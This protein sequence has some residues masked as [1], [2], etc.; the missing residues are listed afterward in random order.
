MQYEELFTDR[1]RIGT[2]IEA[3]MKD[4][5]CTKVRLSKELNVSRP[6]LD[7]ILRGDIHNAG[8]YD[9][10]IKRLLAY[11]QISDTVLNNYK[12][13]PAVE[14]M[15]CTSVDKE[16]VGNKLRGQEIPVVKGNLDKIK[17]RAFRL[18][19]NDTNI[20]A[21]SY[22]EGVQSVL[23]ALYEEYPDAV[24][25]VANVLDKQAAS[26]MVDCGAKFIIAPCQ[27]DEIGTFC[28]ARDVFCMMGATTLSEVINVMDKGGDVVCLYPYEAVAKETVA[29]LD[30]LAKSV[31]VATF[32]I[33]KGESL[34]DE[35][36]TLYYV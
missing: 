26:I 34:V 17:A 35:F 2:N 3:I 16:A 1:K 32:S 5:K 6:T 30:V 21:L 7:A 29:A 15:R 36:A 13:L 12:Y 10:Y 22:T 4:R 28:K 27:V 19:D 24:I 11:M 23:Q 31:D 33:K 14:R 25:G 20:F 9:E 8:K 18:L